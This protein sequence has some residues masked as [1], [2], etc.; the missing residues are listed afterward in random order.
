MGNRY[1]KKIWLVLMAGCC[2]AAAQTVALPGGWELLRTGSGRMETAIGFSPDGETVWIAELGAVLRSS[3][4]GKKWN[5]IGDEKAFGGTYWFNSVAATGTDRAFVSGFAYGREGGA[6]FLTENGGKSWKRAA[7]AGN[8]E[9]PFSSVTFAPDGKRGFVLSQ[10]DGLF[11]TLDGGRSWKKLATPQLPGDY[12]IASRRLISVPDNRTVLV[13]GRRSLLRSDDGGDRWREL[14]FGKFA[15][16]MAPA[17][18]LFFATPDHGWCLGNGPVLETR[19]GGKNWFQSPAIGYVTIGADGRSGVSVRGY[20]VALTSDGGKNWQSPVRLLGGGQGA[21]AMAGVCKQTVWLAGGG[22]GVGFSFVAR[23]AAAGEKTGPAANG[24]VPITFTMPFDGTVTLQIIDS[25]G[26]VVENLLAGE[27]FRAGKHTVRWN[28]STLDDFW[29]PFRKTDPFQYQPPAD[30]VPV[31]PPGNYSWRALAVPELKLEY[32]GSFYPVKKHGL[33][34]VTAD[35]TGGWLGDHS[36]PKD[37]VATGDTV[38]A[39]TFCEGGD[40]LLEADRDMKKLWGSN[41]IQ[42]ACVS[43]L[44]VDD[45]DGPALYFL[46]QGGWLSFGGQAM[47]MIRLDRRT[48]AAR[49]ILTLP[50]GDPRAAELGEISGLAV[51]GKRACLA[52]RDRNKILILDLSANLAG[53]SEDMTVIGEIAYPAPGRIRPYGK[54]KIAIAGRSQLGVADLASRRVKTIVPDLVNGY[55]LDVD[56]A[57][58]FYVGELD[59]VHQVKVFSPSGQLLRTIGKGGRHQLGVFDPDVL[60]QPRGIAVDSSGQVWVCEYN[61][62]LKR[63][64]VWDSRGRCVNSVIGPTEYGGSGAVDP[65]NPGRFFYRGEEIVRE[66][67]G[68]Y[69]LA[70]VVW[71]LDSLLYDA[72]EPEVRGHNFHG[73]SP[74]Y[75]FYRDGRLFFRM[76][77]GFGMGD[78][79]TLFVYD[80]E[81]RLVRPVAAAGVVQPW[82]RKKFNLPDSERCFAWTDLN[83]DGRL[84][85]DE[86]ATGKLD[87]L[88]AVWGVQ[89]NRDFELAFS[90]VHGDIGIAFFHVDHLTEQGYPVWR[91]PEAYVPVPRLTAH[92]PNQ[93]QAVA[94]DASGNAIGVAPYLFSLSP[95]GKLNWRY[96]VR[97]PGL[98]SGLSSSA[99]ST[100]PGVMIAPLRI[101]GIVPVNEKVGEVI[102][103][104]SNYGVADLFTADGMYIGRSFRDSRSGLAWRF[105]SEPTS[106]QLAD[107]SLGQEHFGGTFQRV[108]D[109]AG[110]VHF[111]YVVGAGGNAA[112]VVELSG[113]ERA[114]RIAGNVFTVTAAMAARSDL[115]R[116]KLAA[117]EFEPKSYTVR[118][119][120]G[121]SP[122]GNLA[123]WKEIPEIDGFR[124]AHDGNNLYIAYS[125]EDPAA[126]FANAA[127]SANFMEAF[128]LGDVVDV[129]LQSDPKADPAR[130][131]A[132]RG[133]LRLS[134]APVDG[135]PRAILYDYVRPGTPESGKAVYTSPGQVTVIDRV[136]MPEGVEVGVKRDGKRFT[137]EARIPAKML[138]LELKPNLRLRG[139]VGRVWSDQTGT[140]RVNRTYWSNPNTKIVKDLPSEARLQP[141]LWGELIFE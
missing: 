75:P 5:R 83:D 19:D 86:L 28:L 112:S 94:V 73:Q 125:G 79:S 120:A 70:G 95:E 56:R 2:A 108:E 7:I 64:S 134:F 13:W 126:C 36:A 104:G 17:A 105:N 138:Q 102:A 97:W 58:N 48:K 81:R 128:T 113:L 122:D 84:H 72:V 132:V 33:P 96:K 51:T 27:K 39:G 110:N 9:V 38:W 52:L 92:D 119:L 101:W 140:T 80:E 68:G 44:A 18:D 100:E 14:P 30:A 136:I 124:L 133:D 32:R 15:A 47:S 116:Q 55:G 107:T 65:R 10:R 130:S 25:S 60:E 41:R 89:M 77:G 71:R 109:A 115:L 118:R 121:I 76:W 62:N 16:E 11:R 117:E 46:D 6:L 61:S 78:F 114:E 111:Q 42:L 29:P 40:A 98:H 49:R 54:N 12:W 139:D 67:D 66:P 50:T 23:L 135:T 123:E 137:L 88:G 45:S 106:A 22:E 141:N 129:M 103:I 53:K 99:F 87:G 20:E 43:V 8:G 74:S 59:P 131:R 69:R 127:T 1:M 57:G 31:A 93:V 3:S 24:V 63:T 34:W 82:M 37:A 26:K 91:I 35:R 85:A 4:Q 90:N 21:I